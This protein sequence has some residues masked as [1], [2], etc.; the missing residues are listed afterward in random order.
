MQE[1]NE[2]S[3]SLEESEQA[4]PVQL[5]DQQ[6]LSQLLE[7]R[8]EQDS[9]R[10]RMFLPAWEEHVEE[11]RRRPGGNPPPLSKGYQ[12]WQ[13][14]VNGLGQLTRQTN[15][16]L[17][18]CSSV[19]KINDSQPET[20]VGDSL[21]VLSQLHEHA[22]QLE[23]DIKR[24][25]EQIN[26][27]IELLDKSTREI[28]EG[29]DSAQICLQVQIE[30]YRELLRESP[31]RAAHLTKLINQLSRMDEL[32][33]EI[34]T[35]L[36]DGKILQAV[37]AFSDWHHYLHSDNELLI[38]CLPRLYSFLEDL[39]NKTTAEGHIKVIIQSDNRVYLEEYRLVKLGEQLQDNIRF[40]E[41]QAR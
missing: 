6:I 41:E 5:S 37:R 21:M 40:V 7:T 8:R 34:K 26:E 16:W 17:E 22:L 39:L 28:F 1:N 27:I 13:K 4:E 2:S 31:L 30:E 29:L 20:K 25:R 15:L 33:I 14:Q 36:Q 38:A 32:V 23:G 24:S 18:E 35:H 11:R 3:V 12:A 9:N 10:Y 19:L